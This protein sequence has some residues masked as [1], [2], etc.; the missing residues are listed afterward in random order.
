MTIYNAFFANPGRAAGNTKPSL[1]EIK[2]ITFV[3]QFAQLFVLFV[4]ATRVA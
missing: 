1:S 3:Q 4:G 2:S